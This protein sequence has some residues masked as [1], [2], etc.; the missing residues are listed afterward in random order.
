M[1]RKPMDGLRRREALR[2]LA[3]GAACTA[4]SWTRAR[5]RI[6]DDSAF[7]QQPISLYVP[8]SAGGGTD[9]TLRV[10]ADIAGRHLGQRVLIENRGGAG[11]TLAMQV[12]QQ[13]PPDGYTLAQMPQPV[14]RAPWT[15]KI[16]GD[17]IRDT[18]PIPQVSGVSFGLLVANDSPLRSMADLLA[19]AAAQPG[20]LSIATNGIGTSPHLAL[21]ALFAQG[22]LQLIHVPYKGTAEQ[23]T[24]I[25][26]G[27]VMREAFAAERRTVERLGLASGA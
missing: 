11:G 27:Q 6:A 5:G 7:P 24:A 26:F 19:Y 12:L 22:G 20:R 10:L 4:T 1:N 3:A 16:S 14:F 23:L 15:Q 9:L 8:W 2:L 17:P 25:A 13:A 18:T 21:E